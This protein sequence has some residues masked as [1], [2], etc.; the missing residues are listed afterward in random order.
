MITS[1]DVLLVEFMYFV[2]TCMPGEWVT[3]GDSGLEDVPLAK[4]MYLVF[5]GMQ[6]ERVTGGDSGLEDVPLAE[7]MYLVSTRMPGESY[8][9]WLNQVFVMFVWHLPSVS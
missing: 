3:I 7:F 6:G 8:S 2:F 4:F 9:W 5:T 1:E